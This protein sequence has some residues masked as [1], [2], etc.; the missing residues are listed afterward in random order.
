MRRAMNSEDLIG[1]TVTAVLT[2]QRGDV[3][4]AWRD[5]LTP[6][7]CARRAF[8]EFGDGGLLSVSPCEVEVA[9]EPYPALGLCL[10]TNIDANVDHVEAAPLE[11]A[12]PVLPLTVRKIVESDPMGEGAVS[13]LT[14]EGQRSHAITFR[15][16]FPPTTLGVIITW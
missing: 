5:A 10:Q 12:A 14:I 16:V 13:Q 4:P 15:H 2:F 7:I 8:L 9:E 6:N 3:H 11:E 1:R